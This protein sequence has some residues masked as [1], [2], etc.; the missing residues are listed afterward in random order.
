MKPPFTKQQLLQ[1]ATEIN[2]YAK[3]NIIVSP[4]K[5]SHQKLY[6]NVLNAL[7]CRLGEQPINNI[8]TC[9]KTSAIT[10]NDINRT[11]DN[12]FKPAYPTFEY[13]GTVPVDFTKIFPHYNNIS[14]NKRKQYAIIFNT[15]V[16]NNPGKH[17]ITL[18]IDMPHKVM[19]FFDS[20]G[21][22]APRQI[23]TWMKNIGNRYN[24]TCIENKTVHQIANTECGIY[25][26]YFIKLRLSGKSCEDINQ[27]K[28]GDHKMLLF[29]SSLNL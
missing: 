1:I 23:N 14:L 9:K 11:I 21:N 27:M 3:H 4:E 2:I 10:S 26:L 25:S 22:K 20:F 24:L 28:L 15:D 12:Y 17:W 7:Q 16:Y 5:Q 29:R 13:L 19:C 18:F 8:Q 6:T